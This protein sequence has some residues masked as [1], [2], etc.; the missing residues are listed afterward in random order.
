M[1][2]VTEV[3][4]WADADAAMYMTQDYELE[5]TKI[6][7]DDE[8]E[9]GNN[10]LMKEV[11][12]VK[13]TMVRLKDGD[14]HLC[15]SSCSYATVC[16]KTGDLVC[17][18]S[19]MVVGH[20]MAERTDYSTGRNT[21]SVDP[22]MHAASNGMNGTWRKKIDKV[23]ASKHAHQISTQLDD[24]VMPQA[25]L[26]QRVQQT[27]VKRG[28][29]CVD[30]KIENN[31]PNKKA[32]MSKKNIGTSDQMHNL[33]S[34]AGSIFAKLI[35]VKSNAVNTLAKTNANSSSDKPLDQSSF[36]DKRLLNREA[37]FNSAIRKYV[38]EVQRNNRVPSMDDVHNIALT[39]DDVV[40]RSR[41]QLEDVQRMQA[42]KFK[43]VRFREVVSRLAASLWRGACQTPYMGKARRGGDSF[44]PFC[45]GV[46][47]SLK[48][49]LTLSDGTVVVPSFDAFQY[50]FPSA[51]EIACNNTSKSLHASSH[52]GLC[53]IHRCIASIDIETQHSVFASALRLVSEL[54][55]TF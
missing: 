34:E 18:L 49:G 21:W 7:S 51:K 53:S 50:A 2:D 8:D 19:S 35:D 9:W 54:T 32:R 22:D 24:S 55:S 14:I 29:L 17:P 36:V 47:Y 40:T 13:S 42:Q 15:D 48:R 31:P 6:D 27:K 52:R 41:K 11:L 26:Q 38:N 43:T 5:N 1:R 46:Y 10:L 45:V 33:V 25:K 4:L 3:D 28:A 12:S 37:L 23:A 16:K 20:T 30:E 39:V 44:R